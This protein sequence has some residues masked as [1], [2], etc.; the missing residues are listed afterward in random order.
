MTID[1]DYRWYLTN[2]RSECDACGWPTSGLTHY[3][4]P[5]TGTHHCAA[6]HEPGND[7]HLK[8]DS[9]PMEDYHE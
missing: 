9:E 8:G 1:L 5:D 3:H 2:D 4:N 6:C 7:W